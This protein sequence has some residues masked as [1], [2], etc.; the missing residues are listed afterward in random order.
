MIDKYSRPE[1]ARVWSEENLYDTWLQVEIA[2]CEAWAAQGAIDADSM[3]RIRGA[4]YDV[5]A[6]NRALVETRHDINSF[7]RSVADS[8]GP[9]SR[10]V[11]L[12]L[13]SNDVKDT[14]LALQMKAASDI[15]M[16]D[17]A[18]LKEVFVASAK[19]HRRTL[20]MGRTH[21]VHGEPTSFGLKLLVWVDEMTRH[22]ERLADARRNTAV[23]KVSGAVGSH[24]TVPPSVEEDACRRLGLDVAKASTQITQRDRHGQ[25]VQ[26]IAL[27]GAS[28]DK[29]ATEIR[30]LQKTEVREV[31]EPFGEGQ[32]GSSAMPHKRNPELCE[33]VCGL[34]RVL[35]GNAT[36]ALENVALWHERDISHSSA[37][38]VILPDS[39]LAL[40]YM[41]D[42]FTFVMRGLRVFPERMRKN[43]DSSGGLVFS[44][45]ALLALIDKG[46]SRQ[47][48][49]KLVQRNAMEAWDNGGLLRDLLQR[50]GD[51]TAHLSS[52]EIAAIFDYDYYLTHV[53]EVYARFGL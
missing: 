34:A 27:I 8:L 48:A 10:F 44:Q 51:V 37:E 40:D 29:F 25:F 42:T 16:Q 3:R 47:A 11:H 35:R 39:S 17:L 21:G 12:G 1:M 41:L 5:D 14:A 52:A 31:E 19:E 24:A 28:L 15:L 6:I 38:R 4:R 20:I 9:E 30:G 2:V 7:L 45:R 18:A 43:L 22:E 26:T 36:A 53:D 33:R 46:M 23:G 13:T 32:T 49:Y 50:D